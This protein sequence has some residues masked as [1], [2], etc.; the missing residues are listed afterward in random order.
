M[1]YSETARVSVIYATIEN[2]D[3]ICFGPLSIKIV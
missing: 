1:S 3:V 2:K